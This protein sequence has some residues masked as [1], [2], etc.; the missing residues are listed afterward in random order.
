MKKDLEIYSI[1]SYQ[2]KKSYILRWIDSKFCQIRYYDTY[3]VADY[4]MSSSETLEF[5]ANQHRAINSRTTTGIKRIERVK[6][7]NLPE[8]V[9]DLI[10][11]YLKD[12]E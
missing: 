1:V 3:A 12:H 2:D 5:I 7:E 4:F 6:Y 11:G 8:M 10:V 9:R